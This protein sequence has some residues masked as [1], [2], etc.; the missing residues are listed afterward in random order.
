MRHQK[1]GNLNIPENEKKAIEK[2]HILT[3]KQWVN[4]AFIIFGSKAIKSSDNESDLDLLILLPCKITQHIKRKIIYTIFGINIEYDVD[5]SPLIV[6]KKDWHS[7]L[8]VLPIH[9]FIEKEGIA[10]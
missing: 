1:I 5:V 10:I 8:S 4:A 2:V 6:S 9:Y 3:K 7:K